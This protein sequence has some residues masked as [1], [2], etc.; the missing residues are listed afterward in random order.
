MENVDAKQ[1]QEPLRIP[2][3]MELPELPTEVTDMLGFDDPMPT[4]PGDLSNIL[5]NGIEIDNMG[6]IDCIGDVGN[7]DGIDNIGDLDDVDNVDEDDSPSGFQSQSDV[8]GSAFGTN[9]TNNHN[10]GDSGTSS[11][12]QPP[13]SKRKRGG[14]INASK[15][16]SHQKI[17]RGR[18]C[19]RLPSKEDEKK[20]VE[21]C[22]LIRRYMHPDGKLN[23]VATIIRGV[24]SGQVRKHFEAQARE[25]EALKEQLSVMKMVQAGGGGQKEHLALVETIVALKKQLKAAQDEIVALRRDSENLH[26]DVSQQGALIERS[27]SMPVNN[28]GVAGVVPPPALQ[29]ALPPPLMH[30]SASAAQLPGLGVEVV[31][32][33][34]QQH[35][36]EA[37]GSMDLSSVAGVAVQAT[38]NN[39]GVTPNTTGIPRPAS[40][41]PNAPNVANIMNV[42]DIAKVAGA[43]PP[44][45][46]AQQFVRAATLHLVAKE[47]AAFNAHALT[48]EARKHSVASIKAAEQAEDLKKTLNSMTSSELGSEQA[49]EAQI[50]VKN[51]E[52]RAQMH[53]SMTTQAVAK[54]KNMMEIAQ[55]HEREQAIAIATASALRQKT[56]GLGTEPLL[57]PMLVP[58]LSSIPNSIHVA[59]NSTVATPDTT[60]QMMN[61]KD[62]KGNL[63]GDRLPDSAVNLQTDVGPVSVPLPLLDHSISYVRHVDQS[64][65]TNAFQKQIS[66]MHAQQPESLASAPPLHIPNGD[67][68]TVGRENTTFPSVFPLPDFSTLDD[69][70]GR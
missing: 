7:V 64:M 50:T 23:T 68:L 35:M 65:E 63:T 55:N 45:P 21:E 52:V 31:G 3:N 1:H 48:A 41:A 60:S 15:P 62:G 30:R 28:G 5:A 33:E 59:P 37:S 19:G 25:Y 53:A 42:A 36:M 51:L 6:H 40:N 32:A 46:G 2:L 49:V 10:A 18:F 47:E 39:A 20:L 14:G 56:H 67:N 54:A 9:K 69:A 24:A 34:V 27:L 66:A 4:M 11:G 57:G 61:G 17:M 8:S 16:H 13:S 44:N 43:I 29:Q 22:R 58:A 12:K 38:P 26:G 70:L